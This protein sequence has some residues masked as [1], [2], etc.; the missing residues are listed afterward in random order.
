MKIDSENIEALIVDYFDGSLNEQQSKELERTVAQ[1]PEFRQLFNE[2]R[3][4]VDCRVGETPAGSIDQDFA[5]E[6]KRTSD[7]DDD[8]T[9]YFDRL[10]VLVTEDIATEAE[11]DQYNQMVLE[12]DENLRSA[13]LYSKCKII[14]N[15]DLQCPYK[16]QLKH[17][18]IRPLWYAM[19]AAAAVSAFFFAFRVLYT[20]QYNIDAAYLSGG[21]ATTFSGRESV[22]PQNSLYQDVQTNSEYVNN[23]IFNNTKVNNAEAA[24]AQNERH[25]AEQPKSDYVAAVEETPQTAVQLSPVQE[26]S[27]P[28]NISLASVDEPLIDYPDETMQQV[29]VDWESIEQSDDDGQRVSMDFIGSQG[30][31]EL[32]ESKERV[33]SR[34]RERRN[35]KICFSYDDEGKKDGVS[36][37]IGGREVRVWSR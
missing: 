3:S 24:V 6:L 29:S 4:A 20:P 28:L 13:Y 37:L 23:A 35:P 14:S 26:D 30:I 11:R 12:S 22:L 7:F 36:L 33:V 21:I 9:P 19:A 18:R 31:A 27:S 25:T 15:N 34:F 2:Y 5:R 32:R 1:N 8:Q 10:A 17:S 16:Q